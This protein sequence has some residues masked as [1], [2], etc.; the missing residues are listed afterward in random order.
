MKEIVGNLPRVVLVS[1]ICVILMGIYCY[2]LTVND[3]IPLAGKKA[4]SFVIVLLAQVYM[5]KT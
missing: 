2:I 1:L 4:P 3:I 5:A